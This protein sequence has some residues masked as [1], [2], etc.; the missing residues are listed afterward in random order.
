MKK[1]LLLSTLILL[2][3]SGLNFSA[4]AQYPPDP[5]EAWLKG[6]S[7]GYIRMMAAY[8]AWPKTSFGA[9]P[10]DSG[11]DFDE[12]QVG[13][14]GSWGSTDGNPIDFMQFQTIWEHEYDLALQAKNSNSSG[15]SIRAYFAGMCAGY[16]E[17]GLFL[18]NPDP[19]YYWE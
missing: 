6:K 4:N 10:I 3:L 12:E 19:I 9:P 1:A 17:T 13:G 7:D 5:Y 2:L 11:F 14:G 15:S 16:S 8:E 18:F